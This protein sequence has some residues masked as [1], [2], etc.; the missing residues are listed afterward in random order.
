MQFFHTQNL[1]IFQLSTYDRRLIQALADDIASAHKSYQEK[2]QSHELSKYVDLEFDFGVVLPSSKASTVSSKCERLKSDEFWYKQLTKISSRARESIAV[3]SQVVGKLQPYCSDETFTRFT[4]RQASRGYTTKKNNQLNLER[5][6]NQ[7]YLMAKTAARKAFAN[8]F[9]SVFITLSLDGRFHSSSKCYQGKTFD[10][11]YFELSQILRSTLEHLSKAGVRG[12]DFYGVRCVEVH[13]DGCPHF[14]IN[15]FIHPD[16]YSCL[17]DKLRAAHY[18]LSSEMGLHF[19]KYEDKVIQSRT[20]GSLETF[21]QA[22]SY[23]FKSSYVGRAKDDS[24][25]TAALRQRAVISVYGKHQYEL[26]GMN[27]KATIIK[28]VSK[29][30]EVRQAANELGINTKDVD[31]RLVWLKVVDAI[32]FGRVER[33]SLLKKISQNKF[34]E[35]TSRTI[36][37]HCLPVCCRNTINYSLIILAV[38]CNSSRERHWLLVRAGVPSSIDLDAS[39]NIRAPPK[40]KIR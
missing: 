20:R 36:G 37:V 7:I 19:D 26:I 40:F 34:G 5:S 1:S 10:Q 28:E 30:R 27:G 23:L 21:S 22:I 29:Q 33:Y 25:L 31:R 24:L 4:E 35:I 14:H 39:H 12:K 18:Q 17:R 6:A 8:N 11:G 38:I 16:L 2:L 15:L 32:L 13:E 3:R 9:L